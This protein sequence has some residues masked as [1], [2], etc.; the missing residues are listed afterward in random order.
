MDGEKLRIKRVV[1]NLSQKE[2]ADIAKVNRSYISQIES[3]S[4]NPSIAVLAKLADALGCN[5]K[6]FF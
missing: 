6:D 5:I 1:K 4:T 2:L 3:G